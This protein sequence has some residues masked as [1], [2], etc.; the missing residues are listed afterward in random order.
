ML[1]LTDATE[2][3][4]ANVAAGDASLDTWLEG[5]LP[6]SLSP[7]V[8]TAV[9][10]I[11]RCVARK[12]R[13]TSLE[14]T[15]DGEARPLTASGMP[16]VGP[17]GPERSGFWGIATVEAEAEG[18]EV[19][20]GLRATLDGEREASA[21]LGS[22]PVAVPT[23]QP[24]PFPAREGDVGGGGLIAVCMATFEPDPQLFAAQIRSL[25][26][27]TD[28]NWVCVI[29]DDGSSESSVAMIVETIGGDERFVFDP[30]PEHLGFYLNFE[31][32]LRLAP[33]EASFLALS[34]QDDRWFP[35][36]LES[37][38]AALARGAGL[39]YSDQRLVLADGEV[40]RSTL[41]KGR[42]RNHSNLASM[43]ISNS[44]VGASMLI[45][46]D[47]VEAALPFPRGPGWEFHDH[48]LSSVAVAAGDV[49][50]VDRPLYDY[51]QHAG[52]V[53][54]N[55][56]VGTSGTGRRSPGAWVRALRG[57]PTRWQSIYFRTY[58]QTALDAE[59]LLARCG[60]RMSGSKHRA[61]RRLATADG[62]PVAALWLLFRPARALWGR[63]ETLGTEWQLLRGLL[64]RP[65][66][67]FR[68][69]IG[70]GPAD[71]G[72]PPFDVEA[73]GQRRLKRWLAGR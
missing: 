29:S 54:G 47:V 34:D 9:F 19:S 27:Q 13:I 22:I 11:G 65:L 36:K 46:R 25:K 61:A 59:V 55:V 43:L 49:V 38:R 62:S 14:L 30:A 7:G 52:A 24:A 67:R 35:D 5:F 23:D 60:A 26:E 42:S 69:M 18:S 17:G 40:L 33:A 63:N 53:V 2:D 6:E 73:F 50:F 4:A 8:P 31:R 72:I 57:A 1:I 70:R 39:A 44:I 16:R 21:T 28:P 51:V 12:G 15:V 68:L 48:W 45:R 58:S 56:S 10:C 41:W 20:L 71:A 3:G 32:A 37:L 64:W 66:T